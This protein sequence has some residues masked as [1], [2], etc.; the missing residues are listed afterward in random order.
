MLRYI[1]Q[2]LIAFLPTLLGV[3][4]LV[5]F[6][7]RLI[8]GDAITAQ[9][10]TEAGMLTPTQ[11]AALERYYGL[12][13]PPVEQYFIWLGEVTQGNLGFSIRHGKPVLEVILDRFPLTLQLALMSV[14]IAL[15]IGIPIGVLSA[16]YHNTLIDLIGRLF[17]LI[18]LALPN[19]LVGTLIIYILS[20]YFKILPNSGN[21]VSF[22]DD[23]RRNL[24]QMIFPAFTLGF[25]LAASLMRMTRSAMLEVLRED[26]IRT[27][28]SK[29][30]RERRVTYSHALR[31]ALIPVVTLLGVQAGYLLGGAVI[32]EQIFALP[33]LG[34]LAVN[35]I[36][37]REYALVQG[38]TLFIAFNFVMINLAVDVIYASIDP[39]ISYGKR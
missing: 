2:R 35:A 14:I 27:A 12:D 25:A 15:L 29:G 17:A 26:Y 23:P 9:L 4:V 37:Q 36:S 8:P 38:V 5:F 21:Y 28:R 32:V 16:I 34:R 24:E 18:G 22:G 39:R 20:V 30:L 19:F 3:S 6:A 13:K 33:G 1:A 11:R 31:N 7:M 10:G